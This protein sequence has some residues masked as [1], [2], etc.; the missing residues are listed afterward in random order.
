ANHLLNILEQAYPVLES[1]LG[2]RMTSRPLGLFLFADRGSYQEWCKASK[3]E[4]RLN[5]GGFANNREGFAVIWKQQ[6]LDGIALHEA[7]HLF[8]HDVYAAAMPS[9]YEEG[10]AESFGQKDA[11]K[12]EHGRLTTRIK[13]TKAALASLLKEGMLTPPLF[14]LL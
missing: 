3:N 4:P 2:R 6:W 8:H 14:D 5:A 10:L 11:M 13:P 12:L 7:A 9:W 1:A